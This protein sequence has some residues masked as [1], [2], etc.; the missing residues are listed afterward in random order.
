MYAYTIAKCVHVDSAQLF[1]RANPRRN[2]SVIIIKK[3][4]KGP[5]L[6]F[7]RSCKMKKLKTAF[8]LYTGA[9]RVNLA[10]EKKW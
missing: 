5:C 3:R 6:F 8:G 10:F 2:V 4:K 1:H 9:V 7:R